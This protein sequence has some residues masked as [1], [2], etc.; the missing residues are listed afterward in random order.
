[1]WT[2]ERKKLEQLHLL[3]DYISHFTDKFWFRDWIVKHVI[4]KIL[5]WNF[6]V[7]NFHTRVLG[8]HCTINDFCVCVFI[9]WHEQLLPVADT[10]RAIRTRSPCSF[11]DIKLYQCTKYYG[12]A[13]LFSDH[14]HHDVLKTR[15]WQTWFPAMYQSTLTSDIGQP[16]STPPPQL[17]TQ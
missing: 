6:N 16:N 11:V 12:Y 13:L 14:T 5:R 7:N 1:M 10:V 2:S 9:I 17:L 3:N 15:V 4:D 8:D